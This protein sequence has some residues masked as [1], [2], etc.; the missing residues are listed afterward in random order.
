VAGKFEE[1]KAVALVE[2]YL[3]SI[4]KPTRKLDATYTEEPA[5]DGERTV[6]LRGCDRAHAIDYAAF[7]GFIFAEPS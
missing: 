1:A 5:Q 3:G 6:T 7:L 4:P 2:K